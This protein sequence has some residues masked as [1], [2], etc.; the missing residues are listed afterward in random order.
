[1][2]AHDV[3]LFLPDYLKTFCITVGLAGVCIGVVCVCVQPQQQ[4]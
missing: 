4:R 3:N 2:D 1:M